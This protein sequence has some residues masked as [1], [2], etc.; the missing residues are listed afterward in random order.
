MKAVLLQKER[1]E[2]GPTSFVEMVVWQVPNSLRGS[3]HR[4]KY[5]LVLVRDELCVLRHDNEA[6]KGDHRHVGG[7]E[8]PY[9]FT[10]LEQLLDDFWDAVDKL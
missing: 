10:T 7:V 4:Y 6:G 1:I 2:L 8:V 3:A 5:R 9:V